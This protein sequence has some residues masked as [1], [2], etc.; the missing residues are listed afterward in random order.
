MKSIFKSSKFFYLAFLLGLLPFFGCGSDDGPVNETLSGEFIPTG[1]FRFPDGT[2]GPLWQL[3]DADI[4]EILESHSADWYLREDDEWREKGRHGQYLKQFGDIP[5]VRYLIAFDRHPGQKTREQFIA[6]SEA[7]HRLFRN[8]ETLKALRQA[9]KLPDPTK[10]GRS[11]PEHEWIARDPKGYYEWVLGS[12]IKRYG[13][14]PE[15]YTVASFLLKH[16]QGAKLTGDEVRAYKAAMTHLS[17]LDAQ[18][19]GKQDEGPDD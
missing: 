3:S 9:Y 6:K 17:N 12:H 11:E 8:E 2:S 19:E 14:I 13:D 10:P 5:E 18:R 4:A 16:K 7:L 15:V 1:G